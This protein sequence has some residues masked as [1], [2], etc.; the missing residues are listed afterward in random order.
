M[1]AQ[2]QM[3]EALL[4]ALPYVED[5]EQD[6]AQLACFKPGVVQAHIKQ[7]KAAIERRMGET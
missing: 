2:E 1:T 5:V 7:I 6:P 3:L 4:A